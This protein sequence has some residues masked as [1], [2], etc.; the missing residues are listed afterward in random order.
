MFCAFVVTLCDCQCISAIMLKEPSIGP[1]RFFG[2]SWGCICLKEK[3]SGTWNV[4]RNP[5]IVVVLYLTLFKKL[6]GLV[7]RCWYN[8]FLKS[9][10][11][12]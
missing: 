2:V 11:R 7:D 9:V 10:T 12:I 4:Y 5:W 6:D 1:S 8:E 3:A